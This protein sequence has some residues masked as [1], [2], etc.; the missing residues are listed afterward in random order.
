[1]DWFAG[2][3]LGHLMGD[4][5][6]QNNWMALNKKDNIW[7]CYV[8]C[9]IYTFCVCIGLYGMGIPFNT[10]SYLNLI[11]FI[12]LSHFI[13]D[14]TNLVSRWMKFY[15]TR[16]WDSA[17]PRNYLGG[18]QTRSSLNAEQVVRTAFGAFIYIA[19]DNT[20]HLVMMTAFIKYFFGG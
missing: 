16:S 9:L 17:L 7:A 20:L 4:Y 13:L 19:V 11:S 5:V 18:I 1:M 14:Y 2:M 10:Y 6:L 3:L 12:F 15:G 8:H